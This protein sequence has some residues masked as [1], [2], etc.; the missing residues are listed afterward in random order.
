MS[1]WETA[2]GR[3]GLVARAMDRQAV[4]DAHFCEDCGYHWNR[5]DNSIPGRRLPFGCPP[6]ELTLRSDD[7]D[8]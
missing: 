3:E 4:V 2:A 7:G 1:Y 5:H 6:D 8:R